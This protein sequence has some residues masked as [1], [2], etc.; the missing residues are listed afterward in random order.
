MKCK[1]C[2]KKMKF[3]PEDRYVVKKIRSLVNVDTYDAFDCKHCGCQ[4]IV[5]ERITSVVSGDEDN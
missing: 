3:R 4:M 5:N 2:G 1:V